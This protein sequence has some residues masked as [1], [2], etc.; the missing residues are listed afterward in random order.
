MAHNEEDGMVEGERKEEGL[1]EK[2]QGL[3]RQEVGFLGKGENETCRR[4][5]KGERGGGYRDNMEKAGS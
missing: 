2:W 4:K 5:R 3:K 1:M